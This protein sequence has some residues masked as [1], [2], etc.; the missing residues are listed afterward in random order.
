MKK[1]SFLEWY[2]KE[3]N[4]LIV[5]QPDEADAIYTDA[6]D[7]PNIMFVHWDRYVSYCSSNNMIQSDIKPERLELPSELT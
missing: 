1:I 2:T 4:S 3:V 7:N 6:F 5:N